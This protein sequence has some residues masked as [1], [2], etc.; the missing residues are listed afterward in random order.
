MQGRKIKPSRH[1]DILF[2]L[3]LEGEEDMTR[4]FY[5][6]IISLYKHGVRLFFE[7][8]LPFFCAHRCLRLSCCAH[9]CLSQNTQNALSGILP[10]FCLKACTTDYCVLLCT[11]LPVPATLIH[12][13]AH[14]SPTTANH[15][16]SYLVDHLAVYLTM[17]MF[18]IPLAYHF[19]S[20]PV[21]YNR[22]WLTIWQVT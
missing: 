18:S 6:L 20:L 5:A 9:P 15:M 7:P 10:F 2:L 3:V 22:I 21:L 4:A 1:N 19:L 11:P 12:D 17:L 16:Q 8:F 14:P 13:R